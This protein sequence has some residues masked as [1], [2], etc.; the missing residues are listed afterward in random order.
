MASGRKDEDDYARRRKNACKF[1]TTTTVFN[2]IVDV[3]MPIKSDFDYFWGE[4]RLDAIEEIR[5]SDLSNVA[6]FTG[7]K[8]IAVMV[9]LRH[10][11]DNPSAK[12]D[13]T[14]EE[15]A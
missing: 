8:L 4:N 11:I 1:P 10:L 13:K 14:K 7:S 12:D 3:T 2:P 9:A 15:I 5:M 6:I